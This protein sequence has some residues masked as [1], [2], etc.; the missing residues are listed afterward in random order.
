M[1][2]LILFISIFSF[3]YSLYAEDNNCS[4]KMVQVMKPTHPD[5]NYQGYAV[6]QFNV[7][8]QGIPKNIK[9]ISSSCAT[10]RDSNDKIVLKTCP[11]FKTNAVNATKYMRFNPPI[12]NDGNLCEMVNITHEYKF[13]IYNFKLEYDDFFLREDLKR[14][15]SSSGSSQ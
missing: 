8:K 9:A 6:V 2:F 13:S 10:T 4:S 14:T 1:K 12:D 15:K 3:N 11:F 5:T 7:D